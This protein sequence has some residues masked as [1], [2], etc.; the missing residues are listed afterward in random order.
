MGGAARAAYR[1]HQGLQRIGQDSRMLVAAKSSDDPAVVQFKVPRDLPSLVWRRLRRERIARDFRRYRTSRPVGYELFSD[2][3]SE[4]GSTLLPQIPECDVVNLHWVSGLVDYEAFFSRIPASKPVVWTLH[5]MNPFTGGC[6]YDMACGRYT[7]GCHA[8]PQLGSTRQQDLACR[9]W[10]RKQRIFSRVPAS[11]LHIVAPSRWL[12]EE[13]RRSSLFRNFSVSVV[14]YGLDLEAFAPRDPGGVRSLLGIPADARVALFVAD[15][16]DNRRKGFA[17]LVEALNQCAG[18]V[19]GLMLMSLGH[20]APQ[21]NVRLPWMHSMVYSAADVFVI[22]S[23]QDN[24]PNTVLEA[25]ACGT[26]VIGVGVGGIAEMVRKGLNGLAV[27]RA[28][29]G[30]LAA[31]IKDLMNGTGQLQEMKVACRRIAM[32]EYPLELQARRYVQIYESLL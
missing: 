19:P 31:A 24:L 11:R 20:H 10:R 15:G 18:M 32:D 26:P 8:C 9:I 27:P 6:H 14:P 13:V 7:T 28:D 2:D 25:M 30:A 4:Y 17:L 21:V 3:R 23:L 5:D 1:L 16:L 29:A 22:C 12:G